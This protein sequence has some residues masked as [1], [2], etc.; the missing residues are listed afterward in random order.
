MAEKLQIVSVEKPDWGVIGG[1]I[2]H[3]NKEQAGDNNFERLCFVL[4]SR[5]QAIVGGVIADTHWEWLYID[6]LWINDELRGRGHG[7]RLLTLAEEAARE[8]GAKNAYLDTFSF[9][10]PEF[11]KKHGYEVFGELHDFPRRA[12]ALLSQERTLKDASWQE[13][14]I[15]NSSRTD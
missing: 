12:S 14:P 1:G 6:L 3:Y 11:Y 8:L 5:N 7:H 10:A 13:H 9:Q 4:S 2:H 15:E